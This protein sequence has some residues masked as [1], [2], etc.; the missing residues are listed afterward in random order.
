MSEAVLWI[1]IRMFWDLQ[2]PNPDLSLYGMYG[3][4]PNPDPDPSIIK[5]N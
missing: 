5:Q 3:S 2:D 1:R 4:R